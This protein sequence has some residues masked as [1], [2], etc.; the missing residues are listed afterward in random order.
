M[1]NCIIG[2][3]KVKENSKLARLA[4]H[5]FRF[6]SRSDGK[7]RIDQPRTHFNKTILD[8]FGIKKTSDLSTKLKAF[9]DKKGIVVK[10]E[11]V[12]AVDLMITT[13][14]E[15]WGNWQQRLG[16]PE[17]E[18][19]LKIWYDFQLKILEDTYGKD[20]VKIAVLH[21]DETTPHLHVI[22]TPEEE[23]EVTFKNRYGITKKTKTILN[24]NRWNPDFY[25]KFYNTF[26]EKN[27]E[28]FGLE[29]GKE[30]NEVKN[31]PLKDLKL[32]LAKE[33]ARTKK[34]GNKYAESLQTDDANK[35]LIMT[36]HKEILKL[37]K[38]LKVLTSKLERFESLEEL[39]ASGEISAR[40]LEAVGL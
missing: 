3:Q 27:K 19:E 6:M 11:N 16:T 36:Q 10:K 32:I 7:E 12:L 28:K 21:L 15:Y 20:A 4:E 8:K 18:E 26:C 29:R 14:P 23:K 13:S 25:Q 31:I 33:I 35:A 24:N 34:L 39:K 30:N 9:Y 38:D 5:I 40:A 17:F 22:V 2:F 37:Q 1:N